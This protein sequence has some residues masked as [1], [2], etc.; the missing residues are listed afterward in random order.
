[1]SLVDAIAA[2]DSVDPVEREVDFLELW[3]GHCAKLPLIQMAAVGGALAD[4]FA[5]I[6]AAGYQAAVLIIDR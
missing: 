3:Q 5:W 2:V 4:R 6:F 1:M